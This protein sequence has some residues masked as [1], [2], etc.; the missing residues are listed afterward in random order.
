MPSKITEAQAQEATARGRQV[1]ASTP[2]AIAAR[3]NP[4]THKIVVELNNLCEFSFPPE[5]AQGLTE[6][7]QK[8]LSQIEVSP[9]GLAL[10]WPLLDAD[11]Y[12]PSLIQGIF[13]SKE[14]M[15][16]IGSAGGSRTSE[17][18][19]KAAQSNGKLGGRPRKV[20]VLEAA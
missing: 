9:T 18:K 15:R 19:R 6:G 13:G 3:F 12:V 10:H 1:L 7:T 14:W 20:K 2:V 8:Q 16:R 5:V 17:V 11:L 4:R